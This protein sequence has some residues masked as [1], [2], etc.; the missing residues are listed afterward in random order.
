[1]T[2]HSSIPFELSV[3]LWRHC[4]RD[5][6]AWKHARFRAYVIPRL[7]V[8]CG[9]VVLG[10]LDEGENRGIPIQLSRQPIPS[11]RFGLAGSRHVRLTWRYVFGA[12]SFLGVACFNWSFFEHVCLSLFCFSAQVLLIYPQFSLKS[13]KK[14]TT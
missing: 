12:W 3:R 2:I 14:S 13:P 9:G 4:Y 8:C 7:W 11:F 1:M 10:D 6:E 5:L